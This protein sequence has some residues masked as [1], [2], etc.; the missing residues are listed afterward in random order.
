M[1]NCRV[2]QL[3]PLFYLL[4]ILFTLYFI[5]NLYIIPCFSLSYIHGEKQNGIA[6]NNET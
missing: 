2:K 3:T 4:S 5:S 6:N 1:I